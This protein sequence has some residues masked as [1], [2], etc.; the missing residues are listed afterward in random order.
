ML[1]DP[2]HGRWTYRVT[3][4][5]DPATSRRRVINGKSYTTARA[6]RAAL[7]K[8]LVAKDENRLEK[9][10]TETVASYAA[11]WLPRRQTTGKRPLKATT[12][13]NYARYIDQDIA[14]SA[15]GR[16]RL[17]DVRRADVQKFVEGLTASGRGATTVNRIL[18]VVQGIFT[19]AVKDDL[20]PV[21]VARGIDGPTVTQQRPD[22][23]TPEQLAA[24]LRAASEH[25]L[26]ALFEVA[27]YVALRRGEV[28]G[29]RWADVNLTG[30]V[31]TIANNRVKIDGQVLDQTV[32]TDASAT[33]LGIP[34]E[35][36]SALTGWKLRQDLERD[37]W[38]EAWQA[39]GYVFTMEDGRPLDPPYVTRLFNRLR[40]KTEEALQAEQLAPVEDVLR[41]ARPELTDDAVT[42]EA[43]RVLGDGL[44]RMSELT[45]HGLRHLAATFM[46]EEGH[47]IA[48]VSKA[49]RH[50][51]V[52]VTEG[53][54]TH[55]RQGEQRATFSAIGARLARGDAHTLHTHAPK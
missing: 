8:D 53:V 23:W 36:V 11:V 13:A 30:G 25:R 51:S 47:D 35:A 20:I 18:A 38:G 45:L 16:M 21:N 40:R 2:K 50:S 48:H 17:S 29:V 14:P 39:T 10:T 37:E 55:M 1:T 31:L 49:L 22:M 42:V 24:F 15:L 4:G 9:P 32:K 44:V 28:C 34:E 19:G 54:Y 5:T 26:G 43:R 52:G 3:D 6:A 12:A 33:A 27:L 41:K 46:W 7:R